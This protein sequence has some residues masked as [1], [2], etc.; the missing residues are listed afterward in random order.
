MIKMNV[1]VI[2]GGKS[3]EKDVSVITGFQAYKSLDTTIY[4]VALIYIDENGTWWSYDK[5][6]KL[7][8]IKTNKKKK[9]DLKL[10]KPTFS[11]LRFN[12]V[13]IQ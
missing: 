7:E 3:V 2:F 12:I 4:N 5:I 10:M 11:A 9:V 6:D 13:D 8:E 1:A